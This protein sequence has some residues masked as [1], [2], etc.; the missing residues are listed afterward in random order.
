MTGGVST[1]R[2][3]GH[4]LVWAIAGLAL[5]ILPLSVASGF[6]TV[7][8]GSQDAEHERITRA[9]LTQLAPKT[10]DE[11]AGT[12]L[13]FG[14][15]GAPDIWLALSSEAHCDGADYLAPAPGKPAYPQTEADAGA[16]LEA[17]RTGIRR[18]IEAAVT[19]AAP[20]ADPGMLN[21]SLSCAFTGSPGRAKCAVL[22][23]LGIALHASQDFYSHSNWVDTPAGGAISVSNPPGLGNSGKAP[24]LDLRRNDALPPGLITGCFVGKPESMF[25]SPNGQD[26]VRH[27]SLNKDTGPITAGVGGAGTT[28][29]GGVN[30]NFGKAVAAAIDDTKDKWAY[31]EERVVAAYGAKEGARILCV[32]KSDSYSQCPTTE[33]PQAASADPFSIRRSGNDGSRMI[34]DATDA[35]QQPARLAQSQAEMNNLANQAKNMEDNALLN[36]LT[37]GLAAYNT[38]VAEVERR[39]ALEQQQLAAEI[40]RQQAAARQQYALQQQSNSAR[41][42]GMPPTV[43]DTSG[44]QPTARAQPS[45]GANDYAA[46]QKAMVDASNAEAKANAEALESRNLQELSRTASKCIGYRPGT[47]GTFGGAALLT[48]KCGY[49]ISVTWCYQSVDKGSWG[50]DAFE[51]SQN[52][53]GLTDIGAGSQAGISSG[54]PGGSLVWAACARPLA[55]R[56][57][58][59]GSGYTCQ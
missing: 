31:F 46:R 4:V 43:V 32:L 45:S 27:A 37:G 22:E 23:E 44:E 54:G 3:L 35:S 55:A 28:P 5:S 40:D 25:C 50:E 13:S 53:T 1:R 42:P 41:P 16:K 6:G 20:L 58:H 47:G 29:R 10:L 48:N 7:R 15:V 19:A 30:G 56:G 57:W 34:A 36:T 24:W 17:C 12:N 11:M 18:H 38:A 59:G 9:A 51:C 49:A 2:L 14:A 39:Q 52:K 8:P 21:T 26:R 33:E